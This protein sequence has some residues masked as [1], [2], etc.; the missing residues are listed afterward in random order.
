LTQFN[1]EQYIFQECQLYQTVNS[2][3]FYRNIGSE[4][5]VEKENKLECTDCGDPGIGLDAPSKLWVKDRFV[6][7]LGV[8]DIMEEVFRMRLKDRNRIT[9]ELMSRFL[10][11]NQIKEELE[12]DYRLALI[13]EYE[14]RQEPYI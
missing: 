1:G 14:R 10:L 12:R 9:E 2:V 3:N 11:N 6:D 8:D 13:D 5:M 4:L 7:A